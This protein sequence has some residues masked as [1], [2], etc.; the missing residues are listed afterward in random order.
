MLTSLARK[1]SLA[2]HRQI[3]PKIRRHELASKSIKAL[4]IRCFSEIKVDNESGNIE[5]HWSDGRHSDVPYEFLRDNCQC[6]S[7]F[8]EPATQS[9][10][11]LPDVLREAQQGIDTAEL[12]QDEIVVQWKSGHLSKFKLDWLRKR[13]FAEPRPG[14]VGDLEHILWGSEH[15]ANL[16]FFNF[17]KL[18]ES[19]SYLLE[20]MK[21][22]T[23]EG[24]SVLQDAAR[25]P[26]QLRVLAK[27]AFGS[28]YNTM[29][30]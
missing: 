22:L 5:M 11:L 1:F 8:Y 10:T 20:W 30:G 29:Y 25:K 21:I 27:R 12:Y 16:K 14:T 18:M 4:F 2:T 13:V 6:P 7:C 24:I 17:A 19:D 26:D 28:L 9:L 15:S 23:T 3:V